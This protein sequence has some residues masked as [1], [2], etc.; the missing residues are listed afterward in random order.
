MERRCFGRVQQTKPDATGKQLHYIACL[1]QSL[2]IREAVEEQHM[3]QGEAGVL[4]RRL[5]RETRNKASRV[6][7]SSE[8]SN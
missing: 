6:T 3:T 4:I 2:G 1:C 7:V 5:E 8:V